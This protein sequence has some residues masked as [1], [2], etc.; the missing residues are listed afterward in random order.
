MKHIKFLLLFFTFTL[1]AQAKTPEHQSGSS[2]SQQS[3]RDGVNM[4]TTIASEDLE[5]KFL[6]P[7]ADYR[8]H[9]LWQWMGGM[10]SREGITKDLEAMAA[11]GIRGT[12]IMVMSDQQPWPYVFSF[13]D[14]PGKVKVLSDE[15]FALM[16]FAIGESDRL[17]MEV[18]VFVCTGWSH[19]GGPWVSAE[20]SL[21]MLSSSKERVQGPVA[22]DKVLEKAHIPNPRYSIPEWNKDNEKKPDLGVYH[23]DMFVL[24]V[25]VTKPG[26]PVDP[27]K[28]ITL[29][30]KMDTNGRLVWDAP[31]G[32]WDIWR[33]ALVTANSLNHPADIETVGHEVDRMDP[34]ALRLVYDNYVGRINREARA[35]GYKS[36]KGFENDSYE[37]AYQDFG[38]D[39]VVEFKKRRGYDCTLWLP[40]WKDRNII[41]KNR[42]LTDRFRWDMH[43]TVSELY[44]ERFHG[45]LRKIADENDLEWLLEP[46]FGMHVDWQSITKTSNYPGVEFWV[47]TH[48]DKYG[49]VQGPPSEIIG[50]S[51]EASSLYGHNVIWA[52]AFT[53]EPY[54]SAWRN[55]PWILKYEADYAFAKGVNQFYIHGFYHNSFSDEYQPGFT[56]GYFGSQHSRHLTWWPFSGAWHSYLARS[57]F[58]MREGLPVADALVYPSKITFVPTLIEGRYRQVCLT[59][60]VLLETLS[61][62]DGKLVLPHGAQFEAL[63]LK[64]GERI[65]PEALEKIR[66]LV[67]QGATLIGNP[68]PAQSLSM[69]NYP[70]SDARMRRLISELWYGLS[71][72]IASDAAFG[73]GKV[74]AGLPVETAMEM[75]M[76]LPELFFQS[77]GDPWDV[78]DM[79]YKQRKFSG[80]DIFFI[81]HRGDKKVKANVNIKWNGLQPEWW[82]ATTGKTRKLTEYT[83]A[84]GRIAIPVE[85]YPRESGFIVFN[86]PVSK[87][88]AAKTPNFPEE[89]IVQQISGSWEVRFDPRW[90]G[91]DKVIFDKLH[92]WTENPDK[93]ISYYSGTAKYKISFDATDIS[94]SMLDLGVVK[95]MAS[96]KINGQ[97]LGI[98]W[99]APWKVHIPAGTLKKKGNILEIEVV[100]TWA[101]R[102]IGDEQQPDDAEFINPGTPGDRLGGYESHTMGYGL[103]ELPDW[104][105]NNTQRPSKDRYTFTSWKFYDKDSPLQQSGLIGPV[106]LKKSVL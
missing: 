79:L 17:G 8:P 4:V 32:E 3:K 55:D 44:E 92:D 41:I 84:D 82:D 35:K 43:R 106:V 22:F 6:N 53:A 51:T 91:P 7:P 15:W 93:G 101:N 48:L 23:K 29:T 31:E 50:T 95:N 16:N 88:K 85:M 20:K 56:M 87:T 25:P 49:K 67:S 1:S 100:N 86:K 90:G 105:I 63:I 18:R 5:Q 28:I 21:K 40:A 78:K 68:P 81:S 54:Q 99:C 57:S 98:V 19:T 9:V 45:E 61:V 24:A 73:K 46:Y 59:D 72:N 26:E 94:A 77:A 11:Q 89:K 39:F 58:M 34:E 37:S 65:R 38:H 96:V 75:V 76:G 52:E 47:R 102:M 36:L 60:D 97:D 103:K 13:R 66:D 80:G 2:L 104:L 12:M 42:D 64:D 14:Y 74:I 27:D 10:V 69:E 30:D 70:Q 83:V 62:R 71:A 33:M